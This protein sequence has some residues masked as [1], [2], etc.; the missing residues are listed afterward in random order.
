M[1]TVTETGMVFPEDVVEGLA[2]RAI[3]NEVMSSL[4]GGISDFVRP[5]ARQGDSVG[6][7]R[8]YY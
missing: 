6:T 2:T 4:L 7:K 8:W 1:S 5:H 3:A